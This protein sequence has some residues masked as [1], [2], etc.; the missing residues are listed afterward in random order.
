MKHIRYI[1]LASAFFFGC[2]QQEEKDKQYYFNFDEVKHY[3]TEAKT[4]K[5]FA[6]SDSNNLPAKQKYRIDILI[7]NKPR[8][9][10]DTAFIKDLEKNGFELNSIEKEQFAAINN[11]FCEK[12]HENITGYSCAPVYRDLLVFKKHDRITGIAKICFECARHHIVG[13]DADTKNF[14]QSGDYAKLENILKQK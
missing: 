7:H 11:I 1:M 2:D 6:L 10:S 8:S 9:L 4:N 3:T 13:T 14:G 12:D 5:I